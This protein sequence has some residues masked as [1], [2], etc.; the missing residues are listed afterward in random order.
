LQNVPSPVFNIPDEGLP[1]EFCNDSE[2]Q[3]LEWCPY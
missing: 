3:K 2:A 1:L